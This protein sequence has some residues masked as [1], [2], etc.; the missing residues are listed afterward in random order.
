MHQDS[1]CHESDE[2]VRRQAA[3]WVVRR[4]LGLTEEDERAFAKWPESD[5]R[6]RHAFEQRARLWQEFDRSEE[7]VRERSPSATSNSVRRNPLWQSK[8]VW[9]GLAAALAIAFLLWNATGPR[10][11]PGEPQWLAQGD[12]AQSYERHT[13]PDGSV[14]ELNRGA[15]ASLEYTS[16]QRRLEWKHPLIEFDSQP[17]SEVVSELNRYNDKKIVIADHQLGKQ[18]IT[19]SLRP[20]NLEGFKELLEVTMAVRFEDQG[21]ARLLIKPTE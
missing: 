20:Q 12:A 6:H 14:V 5:P 18:V 3:D 8:A 9:G 11:S 15:Q 2:A 16:S 10:P 17:L 13:L 4:D 19:A 21:D 7:I 1:H